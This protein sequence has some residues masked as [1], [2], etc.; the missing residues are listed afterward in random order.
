MKSFIVLALIALSF[1]EYIPQIDVY[2][3]SLCPDCVDF[4]SRSF[5]EFYQ[6]EYF[7]KAHVTFWDFGNGEEEKDESTGLWKFTCQHGENECYGNM[8]ETC[9][10]HLMTESDSHL[11][12]LCMYTNIFDF[13]DDFDATLDFCVQRESDK[14]NILECA[15]SKDGNLYE[16]Y[17]AKRTEEL[18]PAHNY[19]PWITVD[20]DHDEAKEA[21]II[22]SLIDFVK[23]L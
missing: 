7:N 17:V 9:S 4:I 22:D 21:Q 15:N 16:H 23:N 2:S 1:S 12:I 20:G 3:E 14:K 6:S 5:G 19:V 11:F 13:N 18:K 10:T 8:L